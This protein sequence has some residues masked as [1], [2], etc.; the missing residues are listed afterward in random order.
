MEAAIY[1]F[2]L[3]VECTQPT[4]LRERLGEL[5]EA[6]GFTILQKIDHHFSPQGYTS[7]WLLAESHLALHTFPEAGKSYLELSS[8]NEEMLENFRNKIEEDPVLNELGDLAGDC[9]PKTVN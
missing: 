9:K 4:V 3:W 1:N 5:L 2:R 7:L 6:S 8:C